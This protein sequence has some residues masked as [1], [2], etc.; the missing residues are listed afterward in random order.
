MSRDIFSEAGVFTPVERTAI[1][2]SDPSISS[3]NHHGFLRLTCAQY[4][5]RGPA[6]PDQSQGFVW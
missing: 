1:C 5:V 2:I 6:R 3:S 4:R